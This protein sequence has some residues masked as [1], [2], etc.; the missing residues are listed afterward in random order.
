MSQTPVP[1][2]RQLARLGDDAALLHAPQHPDCTL[3]SRLE[4]FVHDCFADTYGANVRQFM[5]ELL[6]LCQQGTLQAG[7]GIRGGAS[8]PLFLEHYLD[9][10]VCDAIRQHTDLPVNREQ[11]VEVGNLA[12][13]APG[14]G[15]L[16]II[17]LTHYLATSGY[18][19]V[20]FTGTPMLLNSFQR[21]T[22]SPIDLGPADPLRLG[23][24]RLEW[25]SYYATRPRVMA[26]YIP[27]GFN[28][29]H[30]RGLFERMR[31]QPDYLQTGP[32]IAHDCA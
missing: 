29:L 7:V 8:G 17:A 4:S 15:R 2:A 13:L 3:R 25:G 16:L 26:G 23:E 27:E 21:L 18:T 28:Q 31:Y 19:W 6:G 9:Q 5:P 14:A 20:V 10:P 30:R 12:A 24:A 1:Q 11:V 32:E 22:L